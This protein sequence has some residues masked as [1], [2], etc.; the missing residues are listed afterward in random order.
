VKSRKHGGRKIVKKHRACASEFDYAAW[1]ALGEWRRDCLVSPTPS[2]KYST[3]C[4]R[5]CD[6]PSECRWGDK[7]SQKVEHD[8]PTI[9]ESLSL[10]VEL[11]ADEVKPEQPSAT[12]FYAFLEAI[13]HPSVT[14]QSLLSAAGKKNSTKTS[15][16]P[17]GL[18]TVF[19]E[20]NEDSEA[21][22]DYTTVASPSPTMRAAAEQIAL[23]S[24]ELRVQQR[25]A[26]VQKLSSSFSGFT[27]EF[28][29]D[30]DVI[31]K[32]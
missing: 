24:A 3:D 23:V 14:I 25:K 21:L 11:P 22:V 7:V 31:M 12:T 10:P 20:E 16:S 27:F 6:F 8:S 28:E 5:N 30:N 26:S 18:Q 9:P 19:E 4:W 32:E 29:E 17:L 13:N 2:S 15:K 1:K